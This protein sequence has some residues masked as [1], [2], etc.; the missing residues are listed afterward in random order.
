MLARD[1]L[2]SNIVAPGTSSTPPAITRP[3]SPPAWASTAVIMLA[4]AISP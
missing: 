2:F 4:N 1:A 3:G